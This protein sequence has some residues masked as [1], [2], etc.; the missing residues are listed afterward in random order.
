QR[1]VDEFLRDGC[2]LPAG[3][4]A[5]L[6]LIEAHVHMDD[7]DVIRRIRLQPLGQLEISVAAACHLCRGPRREIGLGAAVDPSLPPAHV[8]LAG[9]RAE[10]TAMPPRI[11]VTA[12]P[13]GL[14]MPRAVTVSRGV[15]GAL[16]PSLASR[17]SQASRLTTT[18]PAPI[19]TMLQSVAENDSSRSSMA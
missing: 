10:R 13:V 1:R 14:D 19:R 9:G 2:D 5:R 4:V 3:H 17:S 7:A 11:D 6:A 12:T 8:L 18:L 16:T 15:N